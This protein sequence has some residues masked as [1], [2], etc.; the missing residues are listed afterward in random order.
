MLLAPSNRNSVGPAKVEPDRIRQ[1][2]SKYTPSGF[3]AT[4]EDCAISSA[5]LGVL[6]ETGQPES[7]R[8]FILLDLQLLPDSWVDSHDARDG[9]RRDGQD[10]GIEGISGVKL[11]AAHR[12]TSSHG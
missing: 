6:E 2:D 11:K 7:S 9:R 10:W 12:P 4:N 3:D 1:G 8:C 5:I